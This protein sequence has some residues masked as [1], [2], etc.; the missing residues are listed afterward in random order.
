MEKQHRSRVRP[1][2]D[3]Q[4]IVK[5]ITAS[6]TMDLEGL[7]EYALSPGH[8]YYK[9][10]QLSGFTKKFVDPRSTDRQRQI[11]AK[12][13]FFETLDHLI[14]LDDSRFNR[15]GIHPS[16]MSRYERIFA[17]AR[18]IC[19]E[20]LG[21][22]PFADFI[23]NCRHSHGASI[24]VPF[25]DTSLE[26]KWTFPLSG[27]SRVCSFFEKHYLAYDWQCKQAIDAFNR[28]DDTRESA[29]VHVEASILSYVPKTADIDRTIAKE[30]T[31]NMFFQQSI[32]KLMYK[33]LKQYGLDVECLQ[34]SHKQL[35]YEASISRK[36]ATID[37]QSASDCLSL[38]LCRSL[39]PA[40]WFSALD[41]VR[42]PNILIDGEQ[43][44]LPMISTM[45]NATTFPLE[46]L[47]FYSLAC[48]TCL[49]TNYSLL[50]FSSKSEMDQE[51]IVSVYGDDC[52]LP[53][54]FAHEFISV[55]EYFGLIVNVEKSH[56]TECDGFRESCG[57]DFLSGH[58][59]RPF[60]LKGPQDV[61]LR[62]LEAWMYILHNRL[63]KKYI[64]YFGTLCYV[65]EKSF[66]V[67]WANIFRRLGFSLKIVPS[68]FP[69][70]SGL[71]ITDDLKRFL[72]YFDGI[73]LAQSKVNKHGTTRIKTLV[74]RY[75]K[76]RPRGC[77]V[78]YHYW[79]YNHAHSNVQFSPDIMNTFGYL[80]GNFQPPSEA[81]IRK[82]GYYDET[83]C[84]VL[85]FAPQVRANCRRV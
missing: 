22:F 48:S 36:L 40:D 75:P 63:T 17:R 15:P 42:T 58:N 6:L 45:G 64:L 10:L 69:D 60:Y 49:D 35:A 67:T 14:C 7:T 74:Y 3:L 56:Y 62:S 31:L 16:H 47:V 37:F 52:I 44:S 83:E 30:P 43:V 61:K 12:V 78:R 21:E 5:S 34:D 53:T 59:V 2:P 85:N 65:Y 66:Y 54:R 19:C 55:C 79:L 18:N 70:D 32:M 77:D 9:Q 57:S 72:P 84:E 51:A 11:N 80:E 81:P 25:V 71:K 29:C 46:T 28:K 8:D 20:I 41:L 1:A 82:G 24:G 50:P 76:S 33:R 13:K 38:P 4:H 73:K 26:A 39:L 23:L 68:D 27:T